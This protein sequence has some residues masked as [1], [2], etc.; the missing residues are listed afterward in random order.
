MEN[1]NVYIF[2]I[3][4]LSISK[5]EFLNL[6]TERVRND[7]KTYIVTAN[8]EIAI[9]AKDNSDYYNT[10]KK[11]DYILPDGIGIVK[12]AKILNQYVEER[13]PGI[14]LMENLLEIADRNNQSVYFYGAKPEIIQD[15]IYKIKKDYNNI[16]ISGY[17]HGYN[18]DSDN[19]VTNEIISLRPDYIFVAKG[20]PLQDE[21]IEKVLPKVDKG[22]FMGVGGSFDV[23]SGNVERAPKIWR[24]LN[25]EWFYRISTDSKRLK[26]SIALPRFIIEVLKEKLLK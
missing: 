18:N 5:K 25:L 17:S 15:L 6:I 3:P 13:I 1:K 20:C 22:I 19:E 24:K 4:F 9:Y 10:I 11:A 14:E 16:N 26:R 23:L 2:K 7:K 12:G 21:W 8:A